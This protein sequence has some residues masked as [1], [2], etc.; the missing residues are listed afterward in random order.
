MGRTSPSVLLAYI[1]AAPVMSSI[2]PQLQALSSLSTINSTD[3]TSIPAAHGVLSR[4]EGVS[5]GQGVEKPQEVR[6]GIGQ[7]SC[8]AHGYPVWSWSRGG[9]LCDKSLMLENK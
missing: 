3:R 9:A 6:C 5:Q 4:V 1:L 2:N 7:S 8:K